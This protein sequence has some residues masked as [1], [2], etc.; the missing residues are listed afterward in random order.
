MVQYAQQHAISQTARTFAQLAR[1]CV[2]GSNAIVP[3]APQLCTISPKPLTPSPIIAPGVPVQAL[4]LRRLLA[5][6]LPAPD[7]NRRLTPT[8]TH[9]PRN[10]LPAV[11]FFAYAYEN[12]MTH[13]QLFHAYLV[14]SI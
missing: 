13:S 14:P 10:P 1:W 7:E 2:N 9:L 12:S 6:R 8:P 5:H 11:T 3:K 4:E